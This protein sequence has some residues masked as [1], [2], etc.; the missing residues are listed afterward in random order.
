MN[1]KITNDMFFLATVTNPEA[2]KTYDFLNNGIVIPENTQLERYK[3]KTKIFY[4]RK[5]PN[6]EKI[7]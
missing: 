3:N 6:S 7:W 2:K 5:I 1:N 4:K